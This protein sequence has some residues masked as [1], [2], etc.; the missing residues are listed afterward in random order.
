[1]ENLPENLKARNAMLIKTSFIAYF[2]LV[3]TMTSCVQAEPTIQFEETNTPTTPSGSL[4]DLTISRVLVQHE[5]LTICI[6]PDSA[7]ILGAAIYVFNNGGG[8]SLPTKLRLDNVEIDV[9]SIG[10]NESIR[11]W[12][13]D[14]TY[15]PGG[16][17][18]VQGAIDL[19][20]VVVE[21]NEDNN[22]ALYAIQHPTQSPYCTAVPPNNNP[23][24]TQ[25]P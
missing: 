23:N 16:V 13:P 14:I 3:A 18:T 15:I 21:T 9:P 10:P 1:M 4:A 12:T 22:E 5:E 7:D 2:V 20:N 6:K 17:R 11:I 19:D 8:E 25:E 24:V